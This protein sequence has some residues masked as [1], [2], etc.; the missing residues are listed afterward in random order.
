MNAPDRAATAARA[1]AAISGGYCRSL[2][3]PASVLP[4][5]QRGYQERAALLHHPDGLIVEKGPVLD[6]VDAGADR[7][8]CA[9]GAVGVSGSALVQP[10]CLV[11]DGVHFRLRYLRR[12]DGVAQ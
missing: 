9:C 3:L 12:V 2:A 4:G 7:H 6:R 1:L 5:H 10:V 11:D 8:L